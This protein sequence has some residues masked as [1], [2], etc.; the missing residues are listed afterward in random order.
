[1]EES[2]EQEQDGDNANEPKQLPYYEWTTMKP[3]DFHFKALLL[4]GAVSEL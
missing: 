2:E 1:M 4:E 3:R